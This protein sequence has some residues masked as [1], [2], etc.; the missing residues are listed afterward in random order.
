MTEFVVLAR[1]T[2]EIMHNYSGKLLFSF[3]SNKYSGNFSFSFNSKQMANDIIA[4]A[5]HNGLFNINSYFNE[6]IEMNLLL[7]EVRKDKFR[8][9]KEP[10]SAFSALY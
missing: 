4:S 10:P 2:N 5:L 3:N 8:S 6:T 9:T 1:G 7:I